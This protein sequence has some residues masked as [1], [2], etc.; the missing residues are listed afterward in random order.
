MTLAYAYK[1]GS[2]IVTQTFLLLGADNGLYGSVRVD[3]PTRRITVD[4]MSNPNVA[5]M[6]TV[7][8]AISIRTAGGEWVYHKEFYG[9][10]PDRGIRRMCRSRSAIGSRS[11]MRSRRG[12]ARC[13][14]PRD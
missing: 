14:L 3:A 8:I 1:Q 4:L 10:Q 7:Y 12:C 5:F 6:D 13:H 11:A 2:A 9:N